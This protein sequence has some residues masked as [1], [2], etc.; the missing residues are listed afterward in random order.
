MHL[1]IK[2]SQISSNA[3]SSTGPERTPQAGQQPQRNLKWGLTAQSVVSKAKTKRPTK[4]SS[5]TRSPNMTRKPH[6]HELVA[7]VTANSWRLARARRIGNRAFDAAFG[8]VDNVKEAFRQQS[9]DFDK[10]RRYM[11][12]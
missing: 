3:Q 4:P 1:P 11:T 8:A 9:S 2:H 5:P 6:E 7:E 10:L 12:R